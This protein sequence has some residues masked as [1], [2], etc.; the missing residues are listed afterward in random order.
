MAEIK[1]L[2][3][4]RKS[5]KNIQKI[6]KTMA[7]IA[8]AKYKVA[9]RK[10]TAAK[11]YAE[12]LNKLVADLMSRDSSLSH[13]L[14]SKREKVQNVSLIVI[15]SN[16]GFCGAYNTNVISYAKK[17]IQ[18]LEEQG[19]NVSLHVVGKKA[20]VI[21]NESSGPKELYLE[22]EDANYDKVY[23]LAELL[24]D[25]YL[26]NEVDEVRVV[27]MEYISATQQKPKATTFLPFPI[28]EYRSEESS[29]NYEVY[30]DV[31]EVL[32]YVVPQSIYSNLYRIFLEGAVSEHISRMLAM[33]KATD[34]A[35][36]M[37]KD[38]TRLYNRA[39][40]AQITSELSEIM[41]AVRSLQK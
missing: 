9:S 8:A 4:R 40:Q 13:P 6:T 28:D 26:N 18:K 23:A 41:G 32:N 2:V 24:I 21:Y 14:A 11:P 3:K 22:L 17:E 35:A 20:S 12:S 16:R 36:D 1:T 7:L 29:G 27:F 33:N 25:Q 38:L 31:N 34:N 19:K 5:A 10:V 39:R 15:S 30:P 37:I